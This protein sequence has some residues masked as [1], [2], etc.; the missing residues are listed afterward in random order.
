MPP[1]PHRERLA[2]RIAE[3]EG[4]LVQL[5]GWPG[6]G[7]RALLEW[8]VFH[9]GEEAHG[10]A[11]AEV[12]DGRRLQRTLSSPQVAAARWLVCPG[13]PEGAAAQAASLL[14]PGQRLLIAGRRRVDAASFELS[15]IPPRELLL[16]PE[17]VDELVTTLAGEP[18]APSLGAELRELLEG[19]YLPARLVVE[20]MASGELPGRHAAEILA[21]EPVVAFLR[22]DVLGELD[23]ELRDALAE[24]VGGGSPP[25]GA[26]ESLRRL[27][28]LLDSDATGV[29][30]LV[31][32]LLRREARDGA[33]PAAL[34]PRFRVR[35]L[36]NPVVEVIGPGGWEEEVRWPLRRCL[37]TLAFLVSSPGFRAGKEELLAAVWAEEDEERIAKNFHPTLTYLRKALVKA[38]EG[39]SGQGDLRSLR[40]RNRTYFLAREIGWEVDVVELERRVD[41]GRKELE[42]GRPEVAVERWKEAWQLYRG[43]FLLGSYDAWVATRRE[44]YQRLYLDLLKDL[45]DLYGR[46]DRLNEAL[47][48]YRSVLIIDPLEERVH[49]SVMRIYARQGRRDLVR[50]QY[51][52]LTSLLGE[53]L[54]VEPLPQTA[55]EYHRLMA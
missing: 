24:R 15:L 13:L 20:G 23:A 7:K 38:W 21:W 54:G 41:E 1:P 30:R 28:G 49:L 4:P 14:R 52:R 5:W 29:P 42:A 8:F 18:E 39:V 46:L 22:H 32:E 33:P 53:E 47:D 16:L 2:A 12:A 44:H 40:F 27:H 37:D 51:D 36:G 45:G 10:L 26:L 17:E 34:T 50:R 3:L 35:L 9:S 43:P 55:Q 31:E 6:T 11:V 19:W 48:A 25:P